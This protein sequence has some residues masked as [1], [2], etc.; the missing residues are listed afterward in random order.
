MRASGLEVRKLLRQTVIGMVCAGWIAGAC[1]GE[2][3]PVEDQESAGEPGDNRVAAQAGAP[4]DACE[5]ITAAEIEEVTGQAPGPP[6]P[7]ELGLSVSACTWP[8]TD[9]AQPTV[10]YVV[11]QYEPELPSTYA[12]YVDYNRE[13]LGELFDEERHHPVEGVGDYGVWVGDDRMGSV[14]I[15]DDHRMISVDVNATGGRSPRENSIA[16]A[17]KALA[18]LP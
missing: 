10:A 1:S 11:V 9:P 3:P 16:L 14:E 13:T 8:S 2:A 17:E 18:R 4:P 7:E 6:E 5:L 12:E 15:Y